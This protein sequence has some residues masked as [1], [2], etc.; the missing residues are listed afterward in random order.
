M[1]NDIKLLT[2]DEVSALLQVP[3]ATIY[4]WRSRGSGYGPTAIKLRSLLRYRES[5]VRQWMDDQF[6]KASCERTA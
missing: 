4:S 3:K 1:S 2:L 5:D 6:A